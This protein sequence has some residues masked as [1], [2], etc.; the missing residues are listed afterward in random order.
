MSV[1]K[2]LVWSAAGLAVLA[3]GVT[4]TLAASGD[5]T[6]TKVNPPVGEP[7]TSLNGSQKGCMATWAKTVWDQITPVNVRTLACKRP[8]PGT[9]QC[10]ADERRILSEA[11]YMVEDLA[12]NVI[13]AGPGD[14]CV[15]VVGGGNVTYCH[16]WGP[17]ALTASQKSGLK[18][19]VGDIWAGADL[20]TIKSLD[21]FKDDGTVTA[22]YHHKVTDTQANYLADKAAGQVGEI[23]SQEP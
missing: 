7:L 12:G 8:L 5:V 14:P 22:S 6:Y 15:V 2:V 23:I 16:R 10:G 20:G 13:D 18:S 17:S 11:D 1:K 4:I 21:M 3:S 9:V 19:C